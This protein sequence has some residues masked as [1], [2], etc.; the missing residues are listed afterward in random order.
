MPNQPDP[1]RAQLSF[2]I[3]KDVRDALEAMA[4]KRHLDL[5]KLCNVILSE[6]VAQH[7]NI[8]TPPPRKPKKD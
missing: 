8:R 5:S 4:A 6:A 3:Q 1:S 2:W 7:R